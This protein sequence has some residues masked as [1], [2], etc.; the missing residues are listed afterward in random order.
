MEI[1]GTFCSPVHIRVSD[2]DSGDN[3]HSVTRLTLEVDANSRGCALLVVEQAVYPGPALPRMLLDRQEFAV[4]EL[5]IRG[6]AMKEHRY[7]EMVEAM[8]QPP[9]EPNF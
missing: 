5:T 3:L 7:R 4:T 1:Q 2:G 8:D 9:D 6:L